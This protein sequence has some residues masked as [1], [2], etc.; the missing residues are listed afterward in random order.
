[1]ASSPRSNCD[2]D[3]AFRNRHRWIS[4]SL[5]V[6]CQGARAVAERLGA[7]DHSVAMDHWITWVPSRKAEHVLMQAQGTC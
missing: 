1:M 7:G 5:R 2:M 4:S 6:A 3:S